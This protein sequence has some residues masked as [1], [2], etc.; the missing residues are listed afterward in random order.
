MSIGWLTCIP[1]VLLPHSLCRFTTANAP[2]NRQ[3]PIALVVSCKAK[4]IKKIHSLENLIVLRM[5]II[6]D[7]CILYED[8]RLTKTKMRELCE[9]AKMTGDTVLL[10]KVVI[11][12]TKNKYHEMLIAARN[13]ISKD[14]SDVKRLTDSIH[15]TTFDSGYVEKEFANYLLAFDAQ[16]LKLGIKS[17]PV[18]DISHETLMMKAILK[19][20]PFSES[21]NGYRDALIWESIKNFYIDLKSSSDLPIVFI[22]SNPTDFCEKGSIHPDLQSE[23]KELDL[24]IDK[25]IF[26]NSIEDFINRFYRDKL[27]ILD[28]KMKFIEGSTET[29][30]LK[31]E[32]EKDVFK[33][34]EFRSFDIEEL[35]LPQE[36]ENPTVSSIYEDYEY[37]FKEFKK[38]SDSEIIISLT[39]EVTCEL[40]VFIFKSD[41]LVMDEDTAPTIWDSDW[42]NHYFACSTETKI[43][44][45]ISLTIDKDTY[46]IISND[47][48]LVN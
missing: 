36:Y 15:T 24:A 45:D 17:I 41:Y 13:K 3:M 43:E 22:T 39:I 19:K 29:D 1:A 38:L 8:F 14:L 27:E 9:I 26:M 44:L 20:K 34:L 25:V 48:D 2:A 46:E 30:S 47:I 6:I 12:E 11:E 31:I 5:K 18:P 4:K 37:T 21:G 42:N 28:L 32:I 23:L 16:M 40:D 10:P 33:F 35:P 7:T